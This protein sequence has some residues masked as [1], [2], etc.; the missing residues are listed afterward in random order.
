MKGYAH[1]TE[2]VRSG[3]DY[4]KFWRDCKYIGSLDGYKTFNYK[5]KELS[6]EEVANIVLEEIIYGIQPD[7]QGMSCVGTSKKGIDNN[8]NYRNG[9]FLLSNNKHYTVTW[10]YGNIKI[11]EGIDGGWY[12]NKE[13]CGRTVYE[14]EMDWNRYKEALI[15]SHVRSEFGSGQALLDQY[16]GIGDAVYEA[17]KG[18]D[19]FKLESEFEEIKK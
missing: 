14:G 6:D 3:L 1:L 7:L 8:P 4:F 11:R 13:T 2:N 5:E 12:H 9:K 16:P 15:K 17:V 19:K 10:C 18:K